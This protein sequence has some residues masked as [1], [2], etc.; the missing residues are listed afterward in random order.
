[1]G[2]EPN[3][4]TARKPGPLCMSVYTV[5]KVNCCRER[6]MIIRCMKIIIDYFTVN[7]RGRI[8]KLVYSNY[9][10]G[11]YYSMLI[12]LWHHYFFIYNYSG[13]LCTTHSDCFFKSCFKAT[14]R[15][16]RITCC[17][18]GLFQHCKKIVC[19]AALHLHRA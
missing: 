2:E 16:H 15:G 11:L 9:F 6:H 13:D 1:V 4:R 10:S 5:G 18:K 17:H 7:S 12:D 3:Q 14:G 8:N 19:F